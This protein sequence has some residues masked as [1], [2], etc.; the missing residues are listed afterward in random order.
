[1]K[2]KLLVLLLIIAVAAFVFAGCTPGGEGEGEGEGE[3]EGVVVDIDGAVE[4]NGRTYVRDGNHTITV[5]FPAPVANVNV[6]ISDCTGDY[7]KQLL[8]YYYGYPVPLWPN[9]DKTVWTGSG[10]FIC[11]VCDSCYESTPCCASYVQVVAGE[12]VGN[13]CVSVPVIV[14]CGYPYAAI[15]VTAKNCCCETCALVFKSV[16]GDED[17]CG[18]CVTKDCCGDDCSG[19]ASWQVDLYKVKNA[20]NPGDFFDN[21]CGI[22][23]CAELVDSCTGTECPIKCETKC[24]DPDDPFTFYLAVIT[25]EDNVGH[26][27]VYYGGVALYYDDTAE[28]CYVDYA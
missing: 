27:T 2:K 23:P 19:L 1:M 10:K 21:C 12:C 20:D 17:P 3:I 6:Y 26:K 22:S 25:L 15:E 13:V 16:S 28:K 11:D 24:L 5:T 7:S 9:A 4:L 18:S 8:P 14:D